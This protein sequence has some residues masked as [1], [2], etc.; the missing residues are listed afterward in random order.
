ME[1]KVEPA[2]DLIMPRIKLE[3]ESDDDDGSSH[4]MNFYDHT[5]SDKNDQLEMK[6]EWDD[7]EAH[8]FWS[9]QINFVSKEKN[10]TKFSLNFLIAV[11]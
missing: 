7:Y 2:N 5:S 6:F 9:A 1:K 11:L 4:L 10:R 8:M 3:M